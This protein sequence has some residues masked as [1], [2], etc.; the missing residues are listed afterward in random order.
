MPS[1]DVLDAVPTEHNVICVRLVSE[2]H[3]IGDLVLHPVVLV[4]LI[5]IKCVLDHVGG[6][7]AA[8]H[9]QSELLNRIQ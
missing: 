6:Q 4:P 5:A 2:H 9:L 1:L 7:V 3:R 8:E